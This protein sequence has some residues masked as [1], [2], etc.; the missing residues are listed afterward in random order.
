[1]IEFLK[2]NNYPTGTDLPLEVPKDAFFIKTCQRSLVLRFCE[3]GLNHSNTI[4][5]QDAYYFLLEIIC[6]LKSKL[7][8]ENEIVGQFKE[9]YHCYIQNEE[10]S[11]KLLQVL[12]KLFKDAKEIRKKY[13]LGICQKTYASITRKSI[14]QINDNKPVVIL[15]SG[16]LAEDL[17]NQFKKKTKVILCARNQVR[18]T[19]LQ[20]IHPELEIILWEDRAELKN[21]SFIANT[22]GTEH[23]LFDQAFFSDWADRNDQK[24]FVDLASPSPIQTHFEFKDGVMHLEDIFKEGAIRESKKRD[25]IQ[26]AKEAIKSITIK[27]HKL[28]KEKA[29]NDSKFK[30]TDHEQA[31][32]V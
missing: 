4:D 15:G 19:E 27:R 28:F 21:Y 6:G 11:P 23:T 32:C 13:L 31:L 20:G 30:S 9:A 17:I 14:M 26:T 3:E 24:L 12:E 25:Q 5:G 7:I 22:I 8:G 1:M 2:L 18:L 10:R 29:K 16:N